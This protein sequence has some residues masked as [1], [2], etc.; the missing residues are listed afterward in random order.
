MDASRCSLAAAVRD[1]PPLVTASTACTASCYCPYRPMPLPHVTDC[2]SSRFYL[3][4]LYCLT[5]LRVPPHATAC[6]SPAISCTPRA[7]ACTA[8][9]QVT[10]LEQLYNLN[11]LDEEGLLTKLGRK[12]AEFPL[13]PPMSKVGLYH[14]HPT[15][16]A[17][18]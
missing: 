1:T 10:A 7:T 14:S 13:E 8:P 3:H 17:L 15:S 12:M 4:R 2:T 6:T 16:P 9:P 18:S 5:L 11:A